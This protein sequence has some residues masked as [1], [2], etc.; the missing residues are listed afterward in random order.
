[1]IGNWEN[2]PQHVGVGLESIPERRKWRRQ[3]VAFVK[4]RRKWKMCVTLKPVHVSVY[5][6]TNEIFFKCSY[7][8][9]LIYL[10]IWAALIILVLIISS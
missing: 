10:R 8:E 7:W 2:V 4:E 9:K 1:M 6:Q 5:G 3:M